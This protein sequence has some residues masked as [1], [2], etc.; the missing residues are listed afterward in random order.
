MWRAVAALAA[1]LIAVAALGWWSLHTERSDPGGE[2]T[3]RFAAYESE[4]EPNEVLEEPTKSKRANKDG[5]S[6]QRSFST[7]G[8]PDLEDTP[9][10]MGPRRWMAEPDDVDLE[11][12]EEQLDEDQMEQEFELALRQDRRASI[13]AVSAHVEDCHV[14]RRQRRVETQWASDAYVGLRW[15]MSTSAGQGQ[16]ENPQIVQRLGDVDERF[17]AC[18]VDSVQGLKFEAVGDGAEVE[19]EWGER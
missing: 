15:T 9:E 12:L 11:A 19:V 16:V 1:V 2:E 17:E 10:G 5:D 13:E 18:V 3:D 8:Q 14:E 7:D 6:E 4:D